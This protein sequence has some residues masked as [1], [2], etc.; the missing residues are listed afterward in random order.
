MKKTYIA[1]FLFLFLSTKSELAQNITEQALIDKVD[2]SL[3]AFVK[4]K[5]SVKDIYPCLSESH[6]IAVA[7]K[8]SLLI[9]DFD[10]ETGSYKLVKKTS[11]PFPIPD[12]LQASFPLSVYNNIPTCVITPNTLGSIAGYATILHEFIH[13]CQY[14]SVEQKIK[15]QLNIYNDAME[16]KYYSWE[17]MHPFPYD[18]SRFV[19]YYESFK[20][21]LQSNDIEKAKEFRLKIKNQLS[22]I[23][24]EYILW[25]EWKEGL[26]RYL[27][28]KIRQ[29]LKLEKNDY[30]RDKPYDRVAFYYSGELLISKLAEIDPGLPADMG[31]LFKAM[32]TFVY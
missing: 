24:Y 11:Q 18:D 29:K 32:E 7:F 26:A 28:N 6:P 5:N 14:N 17:I 23:N 13:C 27:E 21:A 16:K 2:S 4:I 25:E 15:Q 8:D 22:R 31:L 20:L 19:N 30:G 9:F 3:I 12:G 1:I 10:M